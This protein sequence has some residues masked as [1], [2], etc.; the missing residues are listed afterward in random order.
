MEVCLRK[1]MVKCKMENT[2]LY[3]AKVY[4]FESGKL[5]KKYYFTDATHPNQVVRRLIEKK[6]FENFICI[7]SNEKNNN[8]FY[9]ISKNKVQIM[10]K[11]N[12]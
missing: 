11:K 1:K 7:V 5:V 3:K 4:D 12:D 10:G 6:I 2:K 8:W 9:S